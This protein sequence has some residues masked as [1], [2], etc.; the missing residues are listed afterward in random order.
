MSKIL[1]Y[2]LKNIVIWPDDVR[3]ILKFF[4]I[5]SILE[6]KILFPDPWP[7][8]KHKNRR[9]IQN[10]FIKIIYP[11]IKHHGTITIATDH[12]M[13]KKWVLEKFQNYKEFEWIVESSNDWRFRPNDC[14]QTKYE[15][16]SI[17]QQRKPS[18]FIFKKK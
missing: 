7:K 3:K 8:R 11:V 9:L 15:Q 2:N 17:N 6:I 4:P 14:F 10:E 18:W 13:L 16:K 1:Q 12:D 5:K